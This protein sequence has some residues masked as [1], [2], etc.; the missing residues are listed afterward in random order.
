[1]THIQTSLKKAVKY[2]KWNIS[3]ST[4]RTLYEYEIK[5]MFKVAYPKL[6]ILKMNTSS[7]YQ[8]GDTLHKIRC[9][10]YAIKSVHI[11]VAY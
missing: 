6:K 4:A 9:Q 10:Y 8:T 11:K 2:S 7:K 3:T 1:M 5:N